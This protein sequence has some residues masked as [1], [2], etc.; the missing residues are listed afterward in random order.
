VRLWSLHPKYLDARGLVALWR[1]GLLAQKVLDGKTKGYRNHPQLE[2][3]KAH[4]DPKAAIGLYL[5][6]VYEEAVWR[7]YKFQKNKIKKIR[8]GIP[9]VRV[10][11]GQ[12]IYEWK[13]LKKKLGRRAPSKLEE[14]QKV[15]KPQ[16]HPLFRVAPGGVE[17]WEKVN[18]KMP[19]ISKMKRRKNSEKRSK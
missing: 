7:G 16:A 12:L 9:L 19:N 6:C 14:I 13:H 17:P 10:K 18:K 5:F 11:R 1:E 15:A 2:R 8:L 4:P 3:F